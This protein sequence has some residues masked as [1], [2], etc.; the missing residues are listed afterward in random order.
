MTISG[1]R[2][3]PRLW[4]TATAAIV[5][6]IMLQL[7][8][9]QLSR[10]REKESRQE[11]LDLRSQQPA[12]A[13]PAVPVKLEDLQ[14]RHVEVSG[15]YVPKHTIYLDN[16]I[17][18]GMAGY[19]IITPLRIGTSSMHVLINR[20]WAAADRDRRKLPEVVIPGG[21]VV[22]SGV[23]TSATQK[24]L[25]LSDELVSGQV[26]ENLDLERYRTATGL[27]LQPVMILQQ[28][29]IKDGLVRQWTRPDSGA[30]KNLGYAFQ[31]FAMAFAVSIIYLVLSVKRE[32]SKSK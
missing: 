24:T 10:A 9:W 6:I 23:A 19:H 3:T 17:Y 14:Y 26:W 25:E 12:V 5:I 13:L 18:K 32:H 29:D 8:N 2:F 16:K 1:W 28:D 31:W 4:S 15:V 27:T 20:G 11:Q 22:I 30:G 7:G 21:T